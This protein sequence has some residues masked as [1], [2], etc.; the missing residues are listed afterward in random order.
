MHA[1]PSQ[2]QGDSH[3]S[4]PLTLWVLRTDVPWGLLCLGEKTWWVFGANKKAQGRMPGPQCCLFGGA[5]L[6]GTFGWRLPDH[7]PGTF[8]REFLLQAEAA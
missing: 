8:L 5:P 4:R 1:E 6:Q 3:S 2:V 7:L